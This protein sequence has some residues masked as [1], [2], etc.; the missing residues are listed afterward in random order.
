MDDKCQ[1]HETPRQLTIDKS[2]N[3]NIITR[4]EY[5]AADNLFEHVLA[6]FTSQLRTVQTAEWRLFLRDDVIDR[7]ILFVFGGLQHISDSFVVLV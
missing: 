2:R 3:F 5:S 1:L 6:L 4:S 7:Q